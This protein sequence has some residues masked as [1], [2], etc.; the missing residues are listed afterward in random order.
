MARHTA[1]KVYRQLE[2]DKVFKQLETVI[3]AA[4]GSAKEVLAKYESKTMREFIEQVC[5][6]NLIQVTF[7]YIGEQDVED[8]K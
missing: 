3:E 2:A 8:S 1:N 4:G 5:I 7:K 6:S